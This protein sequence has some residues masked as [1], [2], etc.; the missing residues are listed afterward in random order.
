MNKEESSKID[1]QSFKELS[2]K[3][4]KKTDLCYKIILGFVILLNVI[5]FLFYIFFKREISNVSNMNTS[6]S[7]EIEK[8][9]K[10]NDKLTKETNKYFINLFYSVSVNGQLITDILMSK[11]EYN[12][13]MAW[14]NIPLTERFFMCYKTS[15]DGELSD[16]FRRDCDFGNK[17][18]VLIMTDKNHR[19]GAVLTR[20]NNTN[21]II[22]DSDAFL[23][24]LDTLKKF[25]I[26][27]PA[28]AYYNYQQGFF[29]FGED[30]LVIKE[31]YNATAVS[32]SKFPNGNYGTQGDTLKDLIG[33]EESN[34]LIDE[35]EIIIN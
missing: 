27:D 11:T 13:I 2:E 8:Y 18:V 9:E 29:T 14:G 10:E 24:N 6:L 33:E 7:N 1:Y 25:P 32:Y 30:D 21:E 31:H 17:L 3:E 16:H 20:F 4:R 26:K 5:S 12:Q 35:M 22:N 15:F 23:F 19:F 28:K 34:F